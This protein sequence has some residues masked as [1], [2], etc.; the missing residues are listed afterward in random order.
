MSS[1]IV[2]DDL[3]L[4]CDMV[5]AAGLRARYG[6]RNSRTEASNGKIAVNIVQ[7]KT[8]REYGFDV[9]GLTADMVGEFQ[10]LWEY[11]DAGA[12]GFLM[13]DPV[14]F[15]VATG[16]GLMA[17]YTTALVGTIGLGYGVP[18]YRLY[19]RYTALG[20]TGRTRDRRVEYPVAGP[21]L[22]RGASPVTIG[23]APG[24]A[25]VS[26]TTG[27]VTFVADVSQA[28]SSITV[29]ASTTLV[30]PDSVGLYAAVSVG[31]RVYITGVTG[32]AGAVL[33]G[34]S[35]VVASKSGT[36]IVL[37]TSTSG[38]A[39]T[40]T[41]TAAKYPQ[42]SEALTWTGGLYVPVHFAQDDFE[43]ALARPGADQDDRLFIGST[44]T[45]AEVPE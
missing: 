19:R 42:A 8:L 3:I 25:A 38:L 26:L 32:T 1:L 39:V 29:G 44:V 14:D 30:M 34:A 24:N 4:P 5:L 11:T 12:Y 18:S 37:S 43:W 23:V 13:E 28:P 27:L 17:P 15:T 22:M 31:Q 41:G 7:A 6:R 9:A 16:Q 36:D 10:G 35:H 2:Y 33:N 20:V 40:L 45:L 21:A